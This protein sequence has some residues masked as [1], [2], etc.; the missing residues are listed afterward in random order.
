VREAQRR[1]KL[2]LAVGDDPGEVVPNPQHTGADLFVLAEGV[3]HSH[4]VGDLGVDARAGEG[5][6]RVDELRRGRHAVI[7]HHVE[8]GAVPRGSFV[9]PSKQT[10]Q[11]FVLSRQRGAYGPALRPVAM[12]GMIAAV[13]PAHHELRPSLR[14]EI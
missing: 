3:S 2:A 7:A 5:G 8:G 14:R 9:Q 6:H 10:A 11:R 13:P 4:A 12:R 1:R